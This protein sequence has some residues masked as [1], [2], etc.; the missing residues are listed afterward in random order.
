MTRIRT[1]AADEAAGELADI[2]AELTRS[3]G[4]LAEVHKIQSLHPESI[5]DHM[6]LY[7]TVMF[8]RSPLSRPEREM[9]AVVV[10]ATNG[11]AY[12]IEHH[13]QALLHFW[14]DRA[15]LDAL[16]EHRAADPAL[17]AREAALCRYAELVTREPGS[18]GVDGAV[19]ALRA[20]GLDDRAVL[21]AT[22]VVSY[23]NF[24]NRMVLALGVE[25]EADAG[26]YE[27]E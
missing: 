10:S 15:R 24:V 27:Y 2:Y 1:I 26:G 14:K 16:I 7:M 4:K 18:P 11:C 8:A 13:G 6:S 3:R 5:R 12:C 9:I 17:T 21:D 19:E 22:L 23:F 20:V 25:L